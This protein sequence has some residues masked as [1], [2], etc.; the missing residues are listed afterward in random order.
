MSSDDDNDDWDDDEE[1]DDLAPLVQSS[2]RP[3]EVS[4][5]NVAA[6]RHEEKRF[7]RYVSLAILLVFMISSLFIFYNQQENKAHDFKGSKKDSSQVIGEGQCSSDFMNDLLKQVSNSIYF[8]DESVKPENCKCRQN[9]TEAYLR[10]NNKDPQFEKAW[11][12]T[13]NRNKKQAAVGAEKDDKDNN[14]IHDVVLYGDSITEHWQGTSKTNADNSDWQDI[15][16][17]FKEKFTSAGGGRVEGLAL[18]I[19]GDRCSQLLYRLQNGEL[20]L[21][22]NAK[23]FWILIGINDIGLDHCSS[24]SVVGGIM[25]IVQYIQKQKPVSKIVINSLLPF[26]TT[27]D[28]GFQQRD[29]DIFDNPKWNIISRTNHMLECYSNVTKGVDFFNATKIFL[30]DDGLHT[31]PAFYV[32]EV[33][34]SSTGSRAWGREIVNKVLELI[35]R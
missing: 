18:G 33:H 9:P 22:L 29:E 12:T 11:N 24:Q 7:Q 27:D 16:E 6:R 30:T 15:H 17:V 23:V 13:F 28:D 26:S 3:L 21:E 14:K 34:P 2:V 5:P 4:T 35:T 32:D 10:M 1:D 25:K 31:K 8:C 20:P 19:G